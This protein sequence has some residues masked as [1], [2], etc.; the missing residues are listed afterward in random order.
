MGH[1][2]VGEGTP[3]DGQGAH[4]FAAAE[5]GVLDHNPGAGVGHVGKFIFQAD[6][7]RGVDAALG[8]GRLLL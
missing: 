7:A 6:V 5:Q 3:G 8:A 1:L 4:L 2:G